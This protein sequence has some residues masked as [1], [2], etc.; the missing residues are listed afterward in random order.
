MMPRSCTLATHA[1]LILFIGDLL[2][3][4]DLAVGFTANNTL[5]VL[6]VI[7]LQKLQINHKSPP[8]FKNH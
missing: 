3:D 8:A 5:G 4:F 2:F 7:A 6:Q 1:R